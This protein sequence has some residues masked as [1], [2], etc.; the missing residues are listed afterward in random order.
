M[1]IKELFPMRL[2]EVRE[3]RKMT[4]AEL[5]KK[6]GCRSIAQFETGA[7]LPSIENVVKI[8][9]ALNVSTDQLLILSDTTMNFWEGLTDKEISTLDHLANYWRNQRRRNRRME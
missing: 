7:R 2:R 4:Q 1:S 5:G 3:I 9:Q 6:S 8:A